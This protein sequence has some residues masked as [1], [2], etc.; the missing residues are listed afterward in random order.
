[1]STLPSLTRTVLATVAAGGLVAGTSL[2]G[3]TVQLAAPHERAGL[4]ATSD[5]LVDA[6]TLVCPG[7]QRSGAKDLRTVE[8]TVRVAV[9]AA[10]FSALPRAPVTS[11]GAVSVASAGSRA[12]LASAKRRGAV[13]VGEVTGS[14]AVIARG[15]AS[16]APGL[17]AT[18]SWLHLGDD[19][20]GLVLTPCA[21]PAADLWLVGGGAGAS[22]T[23]RLVLTNPGANA[24]GVTYEIYGAG[25]P[26]KGAEGHTVSIPPRSR[27]VVSLDALAPDLTAPV[28][29]VIATGGVVSGVLSDA[30]IRGA[31]GRGIDDSTP[32]AAPAQDL[33]IAGMPGEGSTTL[34]VG[35][36]GPRETL[37][38]VRVLRDDRVEQ[39][40][41]LR[42]VRV[43]AG[44]TKDV[45]ITVDGSGGYGLHLVS[46]QPIVAAAMTERA[47]TTGRDRMGDYGWVP[48]TPPIRGLA[49]AVLPG[50]GSA[51]ATGTLMLASA[52]GGAAT[53][54]TGTGA[55]TKKTSVTLAADR[56]ASVALDGAERVWVTPTPGSGDVRAAVSVS[57]ADK[58]GPLVSSVP[59]ASAPYT[60]LS[61]PVR[62]I[63][64]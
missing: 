19:D 37:V 13:V 45:P 51:K 16:L 32:S 20:R 18:Q 57:G 38:Q 54:R 8:G 11:G 35:N 56:W 6:A 60:A 63:Q 12:A 2:V 14:D 5:V 15:S 3:G 53:V 29:H 34:R 64:N 36:P 1:M 31:T 52:T 62:Q 58:D 21:S 47:A 48:A 28:V 44:S 10:P 59:L 41:G 55:K 49:G 61:V 4:P 39:P 40:D 25:G 23:E 43:A 46:G 33:V 27:T 30:W 7:Q 50:L 9:A 42:A 26:V 17:V 24:I 22:R